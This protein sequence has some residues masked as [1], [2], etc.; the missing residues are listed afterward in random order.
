MSSSVIEKR[1]AILITVLYFAMCV[2]AFY[3]LF[4]TFFHIIWP[5]FFAFLVAAVLHRPIS[6]LNKKAHIGR[7]PLSIL[8]VLLILGVIGY[9]MFL[10]VS[11]IFRKVKDF[12]DFIMLKLQNLP[13]FAA[14]V[15]YWLSEN[16][17]FLPEGV[18]RSLL[19]AVAGFFENL[20]ENG[21]ENFKL[22]DLGINVSSI[23]S[24]GAGPI[25]NAIVQI[26]TLLISFIV[27]VIACVFMTIE[28]DEI[29]RFVLMQVPKQHRA[30]I[31][32]ARKVALD[33]LKKMFK[34]YGLIIIITTTE[35]S[36][37]FY[38]LKWLKIFPSDYILLISVIIAI[39]DIIP[40]LGTG[41][42]LI[43]WT[44]YSFITGNIGMGVGLLIMYAAITVI[45][46]IIEPK[47]V[48]GQ[49]GL[50]PIVTIMAMFIGTKLLGVLG[51]F[52]LPFTV[53]LI[54]RFNDEGI[55]HLFKSSHTPEP[56]EPSE[57][58]QP[59]GP[60]DSP[61]PPAARIAE[62]M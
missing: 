55:I 10:L 27:S 58:A 36:I 31:R 13:T 21:A 56:S 12:Y 57:P 34:A 28:Y 33:T 30:N 9:L 37:G 48:A 35:L 52:I 15:N 59:T 26:P 7:G 40:V 23:V 2:A 46:Q 41:T 29:K 8:F 1:R 14:E 54:K 6:F 45:R 47:L 51:F 32:R 3:L 25:K 18:R 49:V 50:S 53:I 17:G 19:S 20:I 11:G 22:S 61:T 60:L 38:I 4:K 39:I 42:V 62:K 43:P 16:T 44:V 5:F 24:V